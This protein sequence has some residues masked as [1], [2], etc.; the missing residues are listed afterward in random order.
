MQTVA[1]IGVGLIGRSSRLALRKAGF[2][3]P[4]VGASS[5]ATRQA[6]LARGVIDEAAPLADAARGADLIYLAQRIG[7]ILDTLHH[8]GG[9]VNRGTLITDAGST[10]PGIG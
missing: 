10:K 7:R 5:E 4:M 8:I 3:G 1:I 2:A 9:F 6:A